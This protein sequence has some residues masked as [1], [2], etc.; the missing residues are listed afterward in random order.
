MRSER[1]SVDNEENMV[2]YVIIC[3][4]LTQKRFVGKALH[5][6][7]DASEIKRLHSVIKTCFSTVMQ[8]FRFPASMALNYSDFWYKHILKLLV[9]YH[10]EQVYRVS[11]ESPIPV[12]MFS[13]SIVCN[14]SLFIFMN[15]FWCYVRVLCGGGGGVIIWRIKEQGGEVW[16]K[17]RLHCQQQP[18]RPLLGL[19]QQPKGFNGTVFWE[20]SALDMFS[21][22]IAVGAGD[23]GPLDQ[24]F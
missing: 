8:T 6:H 23:S 21:Q 4:V 3:I 18:V 9:I 20:L 15:M 17:H 7:V 22:R 14:F 13:Y 16:P 12:P 5:I 2:V 19:C 10:I 1:I 11:T 24:A